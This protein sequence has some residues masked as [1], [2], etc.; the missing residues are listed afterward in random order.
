MKSELVGSSVFSRAEIFH[1]LARFKSRMKTKGE[2]YVVSLDINKCFDSLDQRKLYDLLSSEVFSHDMYSFFNVTSQSVHDKYF[3]R[4][5][6]VAPT[7]DKNSVQDLKKD[8]AKK[9]KSIIS[10]DTDLFQQTNGIP[11]GAAC[12]TLLCCLFLGKI[13]NTSLQDRLGGGGHNLLMRFVDD[14]IYLTDSLDNAKRFMNYFTFDSHKEF[15]VKSNEA[16]TKYCFPD[17]SQGLVQLGDE[18]FIPWCALLV[19]VKNFEVLYD[20]SRVSDMKMHDVMLFRGQMAT[21]NQDLEWDETL[22]SFLMAKL[23]LKME[24]ILMDLSINSPPT[25]QLNLF[26]NS[27]FIAI[28]FHCWLNEFSGTITQLAQSNYTDLCD[29]LKG[30]IFKISFASYK[31]YKKRLRSGSFLSTQEF[32]WLTLKGFEVILGRKHSKYKILL[33]S[34][35]KSLA[36]QKYQV[37]ERKLAH[38]T[39][40]DLS[41]DILS[42]IY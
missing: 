15:G 3:K 33:E 10:I 14:Y 13:D 34:I 37:V 41:R 42:I 21:R 29:V 18:R 40:P 31:L 20:Y 28:I 38:A 17:R 12:S 16:K 35:A 19:N 39:N 8:F 7:D 2:L 23:T 1:N 4:T 27:Q 36:H 30:I 32:N 5:T 11:Q 26:R 24:P 22:F 6:V 25:V 9:R